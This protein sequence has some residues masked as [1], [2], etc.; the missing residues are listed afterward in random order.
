MTRQFDTDVLAHYVPAVLAPNRRYERI[1]ELITCIDYLAAKLARVGT[2]ALVADIQVAQQLAPTPDA[3]RELRMIETAVVESARILRA[4]PGQLRG[5]LLSRVPRA[6]AADI[7]ALLDDAATWREITWLRPLGAVRNQGYLASFGPVQGF[8]DAIA[9]SDDASVLIAG[10][11]GGGLQA[12]D[13]RARERLW[14][15]DTGAAVNAA[16]FRPGS[17]EAFI[18]RDDGTIALWSLADRRLRPFATLQAGSVAGL[19]AR[20]GVLVYGCGASVYG[21]C[22]GEDSALWHGAAHDG[23]VAAVAILGDGERAVSGSFDG[24]I[25]VWRVTDGS[26]W[27]GSS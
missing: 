22:S 2:E 4:E 10:D 13:L 5:Q 20:D 6:I 1:R 18:A 19:A 11:R 7:D 23:H 8:V 3:A 17:F 15:Q 9:V 24:S 25:A 21:H 16:A 27:T 26:W 12:W 14:R